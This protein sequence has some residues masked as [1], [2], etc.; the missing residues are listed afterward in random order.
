MPKPTTYSGPRVLPEIA[1]QAFRH[2][3]VLPATRTYLCRDEDD[4]EC[5]C[6]LAVLA[7]QRARLGFDN[8]AA[9]L[10]EGHPTTILARLAKLPVAYARGLTAGFDLCPWTSGEV[11]HDAGLIDG[12]AC[13][14]QLVA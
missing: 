5:G 14:R 9:R 11:A 3:R 12:R 6:L 2:A 4:R 10:L 8:L 1:A 13:R 7:M